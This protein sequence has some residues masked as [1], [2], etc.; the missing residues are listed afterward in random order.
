MTRPLLALIM[1]VLLLAGPATPALAD[2]TQNHQQLEARLKD[3]PAWSD[4]APLPRPRANQDL[5]YPDW[6][7]GLWEV[8]SL[9]LLANGKVDETLPPLQH[10]AQF[11]L[12]PQNEVVGNR[13]FNARAIGQ[14]LLGKQLISVEQA[15]Q[16]VNRQLARLSDDRLLETTV[17]GRKQTSINAAAFLSDEL[18]LQVMHGARAPRL[19]RIETLSRYRP[20]PNEPGAEII[21]RICG[22]QWQQTYQAPGETSESFVQRPS[23]YKLTLTRLQDPAEAGE[24]PADRATQTM[25]EGGDDH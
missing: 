10:L 23:R 4:P 6:F 12:N 2:N 7:A 13:P 15:P 25:V 22:E 17:I 19:S 1:A 3:W 16:Q 5:V 21:S 8:E 9:D 11:Q 18:V 20:C 24:H 14:A